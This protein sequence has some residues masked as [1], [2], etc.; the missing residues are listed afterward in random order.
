VRL[1]FIL[2]EIIHRDSIIPISKS[3]QIILVLN[4][5]YSVNIHSKICPNI[6]ILTQEKDLGT[7]FRK[8]IKQQQLSQT[9]INLNQV[10]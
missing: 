9:F 4:Q 1:L 7:Y 2:E 6:E 5:G 3:I 8:I 10:K